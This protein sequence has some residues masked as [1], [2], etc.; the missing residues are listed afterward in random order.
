[1]KSSIKKGVD[2]IAADT[3]SRS[4]EP[5]KFGKV[6]EVVAVVSVVQPV[7]MQQIILSYEND[8]DCQNIIS[9]LLLETEEDNEFQYVQGILKKGGKI[10]VGKS[11]DIRQQLIRTLHYSALGG[12]YG[13]SACLQRCKLIFFWPHMK[14]DVVNLIKSCEICQRNKVEH[15]QYPGLLQPLEVPTQLWKDISMDFVEQLPESE[16]M[17]TVLVVVD[18]LSKYGHFIALKHPFTAKDITYVFLDHI[19]KLH[20]LPASIVSDRDKIFTSIFWTTLFRK[21]GVDLHFSTAYHPQS[22]GQTE[23]LNQCLESYLRCFTSERPHSWKKWLPMAEFWYNTSFH[24]SFG[25]TPHEALYGV[26]PIPLNMG[27]FQDMII[28]AAQ[29]LLQQRTLVLQVLKDN[30]VKAQQ[31]MKY[32]ADQKRT[33]RELLV[34]DWVYL[35]LQPYRQQFVAIRSSL[36]LS[37]RFFGPFQVLQKI[38]TV[39]YKLKLPTHSKVHP[40]FHVSLLKKHV[41]STSITAG[42]LPEFNQE[43][44][45]LLEPMAVLQ[46][47]QVLRKDKSVVQWLVH[48]KGMEAIEASWED[49]SFIQQ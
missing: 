38:G 19:F 11:G 10:Y 42:D 28:P 39:A 49:M 34:G 9:K 3:L 33:Y 47:R 43:D 4:V 24:T 25:I 6:E 14:N 26:K 21:L 7:W 44:L 5:V 36:K 1:M 45:I 16:G 2:N 30:L 35:K 8:E 22:D 18:R 46:R 13:Q 32:F 37:A 41:G 48:R 27:S 31:R 12:H 29:D 23:R 40:V 20:G 17:D 15:V